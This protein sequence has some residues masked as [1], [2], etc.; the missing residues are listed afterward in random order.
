LDEYL[1]EA[2]VSR[3]CDTQYSPSTWGERT[4]RFEDEER[5]C[6]DIQ[7]ECFRRSVHFADEYHNDVS[8]DVN[9][10]KDP[11]FFG[12]PAARCQQDGS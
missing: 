4:V 6:D 7:Q 10:R 5:F 2:A 12:Y 8:L 11:F 9:Q 3:E 1:D